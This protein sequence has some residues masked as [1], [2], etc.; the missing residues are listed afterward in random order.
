MKFTLGK[1]ARFTSNE[2]IMNPFPISRRQFTKGMTLAGLSSPGLVQAIAPIKRI[3]GPKL[4]LSLA[5]YSFRKQLTAKPGASGAMDMLG[6]VDWCATQD[7]DGCEPTSY[8]FP[9]EVTPEY[10]AQLKRKAHLHGLDVSSGAIRNVFTL[11]DGPEL[12]KW[13]QHVDVWVS[14]YAAIGCPV[15]RVFAGRAPKGMS[16]KQ[17]IDNAVKNLEEA[18]KRAGEQGVILALENHDFLMSSARLIEIV[19]RVDSPWFAV[20]L[21]SGN[22]IDK[23]AYAAFAKAAPYS[24]TVQL[25]VELRDA[26]GKRVPAD[27]ARLIDILKKAHY[28]GYVVL[29]YEAAEDPYVAVPRYLKQ[30]RKLL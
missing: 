9:K 25:K 19:E 16:E 11:P 27:F 13:H 4:K 7:L 21:D 24:A 22:F 20:N 10:L 26:T 14:H 3:G 29:E 6:F 2:R 18:C 23:D 30:L 12:D 17:A 8:F 1:K 15:I 28:R 5:A